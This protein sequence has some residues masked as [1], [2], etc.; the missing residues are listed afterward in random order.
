MAITM[1]GSNS[2]PL[3]IV[4]IMQFMT[5]NSLYLYKKKGTFAPV[6]RVSVY[7]AQEEK[8]PY[9]KGAVFV[10]PS[11][12]DL[13]QGK[14]YVVTSY[15]TLQK[16]S[17]QL[18]HWT[19]NTYRGGTYYDFKKRLIKGHTRENLK[20]INVIGF[21]IDTKEVDLYALYLGCEELGLPRPNLLLETPRGFQVF[22]VLETPFYIHKNQDYKSLRVAER[23]S[24]NIRK[25]LS[26][27]VPVDTNCVPFG[28]YR[29]PREDNVLDFYDEPANTSKLLSWSKTFEEQEKRKFLHVVYDRT[30]TFQATSADWYRALLT[31]TGINQGYHSASRNNA[32]LTLALAN[33][34]SERPIEEAYDELDQFNSNLE[35]SLKKTEFERTIKSAYSGRYKGVKRSYVEGLLELW[36]DGQVKFQGKEG[37]Y[38]FKKPREE[39]I[40]SHYDEREEDI[41]SYLKNHT[42]PEEPFFEGSLT[43]LA[44]TYGM[45]VSTLKEVLKRSTKLIKRTVGQGRGARTKLASRSMLFRSL[46]LF[47]KKQIEHAQLTFGE[48]LPEPNPFPRRLTF[49]SLEQQLVLSEVDILYR[50]G[51]SPPVAKKLG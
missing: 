41:I 17:Q 38:K 6:D 48:L 29:I 21:D 42:S 22:Y 30:S 1:H 43:M 46:L 31:S 47:R 23:L 16:K 35:H 49:P 20:Q 19:P 44:K 37:W 10:S 33:Y 51:A 34:M 36:T 4:E 7:E 25:A 13:E 24:D 39:R 27:Y 3:S 26:T 12:D 15:E 28:F 5:H 45:A 14:G 9:R 50:S 2:Y 18:T 40:R 8:N 32:L 11:K